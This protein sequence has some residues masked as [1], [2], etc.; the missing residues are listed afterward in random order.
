MDKDT[1]KQVPEHDHHK[2]IIL[3]L[4]STEGAKQCIWQK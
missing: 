1:I 3:L 4:Q 2:H